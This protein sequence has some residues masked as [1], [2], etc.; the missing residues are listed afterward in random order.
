MAGKKGFNNI[1]MIETERLAHLTQHL[2]H[3]LRFAGNP[4]SKRP[5]PA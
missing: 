2:S 4:A 5:N 3:V 1:D